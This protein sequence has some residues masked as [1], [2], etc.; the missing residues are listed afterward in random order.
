[1]NDAFLLLRG[2]ERG[3]IK[4]RG[5]HPFAKSPRVEISTHG[6]KERYEGNGNSVRG[7]AQAKL[8]GEKRT[9]NE[10]KRGKS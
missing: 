8:E 6:E 2:K 9:R 1:V 4:E 10:K 3:R 7:Y 5:P